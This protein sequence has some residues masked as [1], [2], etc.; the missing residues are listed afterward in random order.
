MRWGETADIGTLRHNDG[1]IK[2]GEALTMVTD[3]AGKVIF[4]PVKV[5]TKKHST[6]KLDI[7]IP[8]LNEYIPRQKFHSAYGLRSTLLH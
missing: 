2:V 5:P 8:Y 6:W 3:T 7:R 4:K 1:G